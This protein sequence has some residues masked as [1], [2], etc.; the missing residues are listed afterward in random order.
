[1]NTTPPT[2]KPEFPRVRS[3]S[4]STGDYH[5][6]GYTVEARCI[7]KEPRSVGRMV[8]GQAWTEVQFERAPIGVPAAHPYSPLPLMNVLSWPA[9][10]ALRWWFHA[11]AAS[12]GHMGDLGIETRLVEHTIK[13]D[14]ECRAVGIVDEVSDGAFRRVRAATEKV[15]T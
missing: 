9:A 15:T 5:E 6:K 8:L 1:M 7:L 10:Q 14:Y 2:D 3:S 12:T 13:L 11:D 4:H